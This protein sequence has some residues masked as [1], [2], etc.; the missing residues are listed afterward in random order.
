MQ[1]KTIRADILAGELSALVAQ[2]HGW[3][4][5]P[6]WTSPKGVPMGFHPAFSESLDAVL[7]LVGDVK[8]ILLNYGFTTSPS[9]QCELFD[10]LTHKT[11]SSRAGHRSAATAVCFALLAS[12]GYTVEAAET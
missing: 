3:T 1:P 7:P 10:V 8:I 6:L 2:E 4:R 11:V 5:L 12:K 9:W